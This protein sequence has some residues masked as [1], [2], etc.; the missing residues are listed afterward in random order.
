L[1]SHTVQ[2]NAVGTELRGLVFQA[3]DHFVDF[4]PEVS[5]SPP[6]LEAAKFAICS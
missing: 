1:I 5:A 6:R 2:Q 3:L 4:C